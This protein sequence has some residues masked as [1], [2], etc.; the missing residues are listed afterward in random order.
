MVYLR[1]PKTFRLTQALR[2]PVFLPDTA[3]LDNSVQMLQNA[4]THLGVVVD[5]HGGVEGIVTLENIIEQI[6]GEIRDEHDVEVD[7]VMPH[8]DGSAMINGGLRLSSGRKR[9]PLNLP[10][11]G[12]YVTLA[13]FLMAQSGRLPREGDEITFQERVFGVEHW[14]SRD[15]SGAAARSQQCSRSGLDSRKP[16]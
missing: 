14:S 9:L 13:G 2:R 3:P 12:Q 8:F 7:S 11:T 4:Q 1:Y 16:A 10:E 5:E 6:V 15:P